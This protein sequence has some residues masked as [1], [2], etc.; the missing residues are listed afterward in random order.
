MELKMILVLVIICF[1]VYGLFKSH[2]KIHKLNRLIKLIWNDKKRLRDLWHKTICKNCMKSIDDYDSYEE[3][4]LYEVCWKCKK[5]KVAF[6]TGLYPTCWDCYRYEK[7]NSNYE[8]FEQYGYSI[9]DI[10][11]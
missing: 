4:M 3:Y 11:I 10:N 9:I 8:H 6:D 7:V 1:L 2:M 5:N